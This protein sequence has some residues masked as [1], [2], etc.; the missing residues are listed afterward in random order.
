MKKIIYFLLSCDEQKTKEFLYKYNYPVLKNKTLPKKFLKKSRKF[1]ERVKKLNI[2]SSN[3]LQDSWIHF[4][5]NNS[6]Q[7]VFLVVLCEILKYPP[8]QVCWM[9]KIQPETRNYRL[10]QALLALEK[11]CTKEGNSPQTVIDYCKQLANLSL[12]NSLE[13]IEYSSKRFKI[14]Y[15]LVGL[16]ILIGLGTATWYVFYSP[17]GEIILYE[18]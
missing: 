1:F 3:N 4:C 6:Y 11:S 12:P 8:K 2:S 7:W 15:F 5:K 17:S 10:K 13:K 9:L 16:L 18:S 14:K